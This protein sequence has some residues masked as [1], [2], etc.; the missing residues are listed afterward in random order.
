MHEHWEELSGRKLS[1][2][3]MPAANFLRMGRQVSESLSFMWIQKAR[4]N[5]LGIEPIVSLP[6][7]L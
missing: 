7:R 2:M 6:G 5:V 3:Q 4:K 1:A